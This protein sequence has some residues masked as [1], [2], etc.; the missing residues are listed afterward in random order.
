M[1]MQDNY[2]RLLNPVYLQKL[3]RQAR[4]KPQRESGQNFL[5][6]PEII[7]ATLLAME[8]GPKNV[9]EL[10]AGIGPLTSALLEVGYTVKAIERDQTLSTIMTQEIHSKHKD[11]LELVVK[12][13]RETRWD[14]SREQKGHQP[15]QLVGN[16]PY[17]LSGLII[18]RIVQLDP[19][20]DRV[21]LLLQ[22]EVGERLTSTPPNMN[23]LS[24]SVSLWGKADLLLRIP[25]SCFWPAPKVESCLVILT[26]HKDQTEDVQTREKIIATARIFFQSKRKQMAGVLKRKLKEKNQ[27]ALKQANINGHSR[28]QELTLEQWRALARVL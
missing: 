23:M 7:E 15:Y 8:G 20:P 22:K 9:T 13:L 16:I 26:P 17:N 5:I 2:N 14:W 11:Q 18:R 10:G 1:C 3:M 19:S 21:L 28:P 24:L 25:A 12:D 4:I 6:C 27:D